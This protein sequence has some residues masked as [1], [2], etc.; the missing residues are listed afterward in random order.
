MGY[1]GLL[2]LGPWLWSLRL[3]QRNRRVVIAASVCAVVVAGGLTFLLWPESDAHLAQE[4]IGAWQAID[5]ANAALHKQEAPVAA[6]TVVVEPNGELH[7]SFTLKDNPQELR[8]DTWGWKVAKNRLVLQFR[9]EGGTD[10]WNFP[11]KFSVSEDRLSIH[12]RNFPE[13]EFRR[14]GKLGSPT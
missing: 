13:K 12:R 4:V 11:L 5:P 14:V 10:E 9:G 6:E 2:A 8:T 7:Y 1:N 3:T